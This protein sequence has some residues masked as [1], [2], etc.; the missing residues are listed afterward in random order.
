MFFCDEPDLQNVIQVGGNVSRGSAYP[1]ARTI[2]LGQ[3]N[4]RW[5]EVLAT[6]TFRCINFTRYKFIYSC[7]LTK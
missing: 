4:D 7:R 2:S 6:T 1:S 3:K 5:R